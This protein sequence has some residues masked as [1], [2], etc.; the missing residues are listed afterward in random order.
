VTAEVI[1]DSVREG[2]NTS[3][4]LVAH[5]ADRAGER[6]VKGAIKTAVGMKMILRSGRGK[7]AI[8]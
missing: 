8:P 6:S 4:A 5:L 2:H 7:Y 1:E 3:K